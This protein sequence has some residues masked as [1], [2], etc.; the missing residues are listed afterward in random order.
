MKRDTL[1]V[2]M[3][4]SKKHAMLAIKKDTLTQV[5]SRAAWLDYVGEQLAKD[6]QHRA[7]L[8]I[9]LDRF[10][11]V[12]DSLGHDAGDF[13]LQHVAKLI[14]SAI[15][16]EFDLAGR[17]GG[18]EFVVLLQSPNSVKSFAQIANQ[19]IAKIDEPVLI[20]STE[21][22]IGASIGVAHFPNDA[23]QLDQLMKYADLAMY[24]A[25]NSGRNQLVSF[26][27][28]M[29]KQI[30]FRREIQS[31]VRRMLR[32]E[33]LQAL[34]QP[35]YDC[36]KQQNIALELK[37]DTR[38]DDKLHLMD[39]ADLFALIDESQVAI[40]LSEWMFETGLKWLQALN[41]SGLELS[42]MFPVRPSHFHQTRFVDWLAEKIDEYE[43]APES[44]VLQLNDQSL[45]V[46]RFP[47]ETQLR[48]LASLGVDVAVHNFGTGQLSPMKLHDWPISQLNLSSS[49]VNSMTSKRSIANL[50]ESLIKM[51]HMLNKRVV[52]YGV[53]SLEQKD[54]L[55]S[56]NC[57][58]MQGPL[59]GEPIKLDDFEL[60][61][62]IQTKEHEDYL[63]HFNLNDDY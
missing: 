52:A 60:Q 46:Q 29:V 50:T 56:Q 53:N 44:I 19:I 34:V 10:K 42:V 49:Y 48:A 7:V 41:E 37:I 33:Y 9:D 3:P 40:E 22:E 5:A 58:L 27:Q 15:D 51:G 39:Q 11:F 18:D 62:L 1:E 17:M 24:R 57:Q 26:N 28:Q 13:L 23:Q 25:K 63:A 21:V 6:Q 16:V 43:V 4:N 2:S 59:F 32:E 31:C 12:N 14:H 47:V 54:L 55:N 36:Q 8:F 35:I 45:N 30:E 61:Q 20:D 38:F